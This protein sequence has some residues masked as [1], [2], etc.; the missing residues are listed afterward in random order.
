[1]SR[2][3]FFPLMALIAGILIGDYI[4]FHFSVLAC[5]S[6]AVLIALFF[7]IRRKRHSAAFAFILFFVFIV[8]L[9]NISRC[10]YLQ[11]DDRHIMHFASKEKLT[12]EGVVI[13][14]EQISPEK[15]LLLVECVRLVSN[16][17]Y[18][19]LSGNIRL[20]IPQECSFD[21]GDFI[22]FRTAVKP[23]AGFHNPGGFDHQRYL[24]R[25][26]IFV[27]GFVSGT[28]DIILMRRHWI[29]SLPASVDHFRQHL[30]RLIYSHSRTPEREILEAMTI[31]N[32]KGI[33]DDI[34]DAFATTGTSHILSISG[35]HVGL[36]ASS[37]FFLFLVLLKSSEYLMLRFSIV[38]IAAAASLI[39]V[40][41]YT[42]VAGMGT[43]VLRSA[44]MALSFLVALIIGKPRDLFNVL[45]GAALII[46]MIIP[47]SL[48]EVSFQLS[49]CAV[50]ALIY[51]VPRFDKPSFSFLAVTPQWFQFCFHQ[52]YLFILVSL[53][54]TLGTLPIIIYYFN[55]LS[56]VTVIANLIAVP[57]L[58]MLVLFFL[59]LFILTA[60]FSP[61]LAG[62]LIK[63]ASFFTSLSI[64]I[65][66]RLASLPWSSITF[67]KPGWIE[68]I[69]LYVI[70]FGLIEVLTP[71]ENKKEK[72]FA[73]RYP[74]L[75]KAI[76]FTSLLL[77]IANSTYLY[78]KDKTSTDLQFT[79]IDVGQGSST[80]IEFPGGTRMLIDGGG[81]QDSAFDIGKS[82]IAPFLY[83]KKIKKIDIVVLTHPHPDHMQGLIYILN[84]FDVREVWTTDVK[85]DDDLYRLWEK[86]I[87]DHNL[88]I[89]H[90][91]SGR[92]SERLAGASIVCLWPDRTAENNGDHDTNDQ[93]LVLK[94][95]FGEKS[96]LITGD[97]SSRVESRLTASGNNLK[98]NL[99]FVPHHGSVYSSSETFIHKVSPQYAVISAG[100][101]NVFRH[102]HPDVLNLYKAH[103]TQIF[104][105]DQQGAI[106][107]HS[108]GKKLEVAP[109]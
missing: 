96:F 16:R 84:N 90:L 83:Y 89:R 2:P 28:Q 13:S 80:L 27:S 40:I 88:I 53:A 19:K 97:I 92:P 59:L 45:F 72:Q 6:L 17:T 95:T 66:K 54:A 20:V 98:S 79:A 81:F 52:V 29:N 109:W 62:W 12:I 34:Q 68:I 18:S 77:L 106:R 39:P 85:A 70:L 31:G 82:V 51:I 38:K 9:F 36:V 35:L 58:G 105:T 100:K 99:L 91:R 43:P 86:T 76:L 44:F 50:F 1:M 69:L 101:N 15:S 93:S 75:V 25:Q 23:V 102:P 42:L 30:K 103:G 7:C 73:T 74:S 41:I 63:A 24:N 26:G 4:T 78:W 8:G 71:T 11:F 108:D 3:L 47:E 48:L 60:V 5:A 14:E 65:I 10:Q 55:R 37:G 67:V 46:L 32:Q 61:T 107:I 21:R 22:R 94:I 49:F 87:S 56:T 64:G 57:L 104:R 33:P